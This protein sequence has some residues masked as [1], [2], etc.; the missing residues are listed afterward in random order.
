MLTQ[1]THGTLSPPDIP[2]SQTPPAA[3]AAAA[4]PK[5]IVVESLGLLAEAELWCNPAMM[6]VVRKLSIDASV[7]V[8]KC[9]KPWTRQP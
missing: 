1:Q 3:A 6:D 9:S 2:Q 8:R 7:A 5:H 4:A